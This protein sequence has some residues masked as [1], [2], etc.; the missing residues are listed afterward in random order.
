MYEIYCN[1]KQLRVS[2]INKSNYAKKGTSNSATKK[3]SGSPSSGA[4]MP[5]NGIKPRF[6]ALR[7]LHVF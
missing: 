4:F 1:L 2:G 3:G 7:Q 6:S 5:P